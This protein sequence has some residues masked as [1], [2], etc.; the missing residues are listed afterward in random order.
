M[1]FIMFACS[2][3]C[4]HALY[5]V[6]M[7]FITFECQKNYISFALACALLNYSSHRIETFPGKKYKTENSI[8]N[9]TSFHQ[10]TGETQ[11]A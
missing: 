10:Y 3:L 11:K 4:L 7:L 1:L 6:C 5:Y 8:F 2:V 9:N